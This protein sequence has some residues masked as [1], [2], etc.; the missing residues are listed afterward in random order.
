MKLNRMNAFEGSQV[1]F[2][3]SVF[4]K[5]TKEEGFVVNQITKF[6]NPERKSFEPEYKIAITKLLIPESDYTK[7]DD[8]KLILDYDYMMQ[9]NYKKFYYEIKGKNFVKSQVP[10]VQTSYLHPEGETF[11]ISSDGN[12]SNPGM[13]TNQG[14]FANNKIENLLPLDYKLGD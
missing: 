9:I 5:K 10:I 7:N 3:R 14:E 1:H 13:L 8:G 2:F 12:T 11:E 4:N 6:P